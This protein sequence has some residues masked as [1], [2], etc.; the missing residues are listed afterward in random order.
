[1][2]KTGTKQTKYRLLI[3]CAVLFLLVGALWA[4]EGVDG[5]A[6]K[7]AAGVLE[8]FP[9]KA[10][11]RAG[12]IRFENFSDLSDWVA[13]KYYQVFVAQIEK[14]AS[15]NLKYTDLMINFHNKRGEF[16]LNRITPLNYL[17]YIK[18]IRNKDKLGAGVAV[19]SRSL[20]KI[21]F[22]KYVEVR[23]AAGEREFYETRRFGFK[24]TGFSRKI[25]IDAQT[26]LLDLKSTAGPDGQPLYFFYYPDRIEIFKIE[27]NFL[28]KFFSFNLNWGTPYY[29]VIE[30]EGK[31]ALFHLEGDKRL[32]LS[33]GGNFTPFSKLFSYLDHQWQ[34]LDRLDFVPIKHV[35]LNDND[36]LAGCRYDVGKNIFKG[37]LVMAPF[38]DGEVQRELLLEKELPPFF[39]LDFTTFDG[40]VIESLHLVDVA[41]RYRFFAA[42][43][44]ER[45]VEAERRGASLAA[46]EG[47]WLAVSDYNRGSDTLYFYKVEE[48]SRQLTYQN[49][50]DGEIYFISPGTWKEK[51][52]FWVYIKKMKNN[53]VIFNLQFWSKDNG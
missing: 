44:Q 26:L 10:P 52:G 12:V 36:Y 53:R 6:G 23:L 14:N 43:L 24:G 15:P 42:D 31:M 51:T 5:L 34:E 48:G 40:N 2:V 3:S 8:Y 22:M 19:F 29:P 16:N 17:L 41:Y 4:E 28:K 11:I 25:E 50:I 37:K 47:R 7:T 1:M 20:D 13:Q 32:Y 39:E 27:K 49:A 45:T 35:R 18:L 21:V 46:L 30:P 38:R 33:V 9:A